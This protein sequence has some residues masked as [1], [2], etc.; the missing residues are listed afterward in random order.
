MDLAKLA[1]W[2]WFKDE[3]EQTAPVRVNR[4]GSGSGPVESFQPLY[5]FQRQMEELFN[6]FFHDSGRRTWP[7]G[8]IGAMLGSGFLKPSMNIGSNE[9]EYSISIEIPGV[10]EKDIKVEIKDN[11]L[12]V[13][14]EK[15]QETEDRKKDFYR[16]ERSYGSF[17]RV[18]TLPDDADRDN[19]NASFRKGVLNLV[20][21]KRTLPG[22]DVKKIEVTT[23]D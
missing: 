5:H 22:T 2:N 7:V 10:D 12:I 1:P 14:G 17:R 3:E 21:A 4:P 6:T 18:L 13:S 15:Q 8:E 19:V 11:T 20:I 9:K 23:A 16:I